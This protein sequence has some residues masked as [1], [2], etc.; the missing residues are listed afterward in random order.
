MEYTPSVQQQEEEFSQMPDF[1]LDSAFE[2]KFEIIH[3]R[4]K[5]LPETVRV[6]LDEEKWY[7]INIHPTDRIFPIDSVDVRKF[8]TDELD[9]E[10]AWLKF[11]SWVEKHRKLTG[12]YRYRYEEKVL[13]LFDRKNFAK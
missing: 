1:A 11:L 9:M 3:E 5:N 2:G 7:V 12:N 13:Y 6:E 8:I 4:Q 10:S